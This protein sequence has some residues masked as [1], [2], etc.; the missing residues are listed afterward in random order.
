MDLIFRRLEELNSVDVELR[1]VVIN[2][3]ESE[4]K[5][6]ILNYYCNRHELHLVNN[7]ENLGYAGGNNS[8]LAYLKN[9]NYSGDIIIAN[10][11]V[12][13]SP[14]VIKSLLSAREC[15][16]FGAVMTAAHDENGLVLYSYIKLFNGF[17]QKWLCDQTSESFIGTDYVAGS[18]SC[19]IREFFSGIGSA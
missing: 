3:D 14:S 7:G 13:L 12:T 4:I 5:K 17:Q 10:A 6:E 1:V 11:D 9:N 15:Q 8:G 18:F 19:L 2:N 16:K